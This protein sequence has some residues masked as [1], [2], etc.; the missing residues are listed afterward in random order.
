MLW[1]SV[2]LGLLM[3][4][5]F[6]CT[7]SGLLVGSV[8]DNKHKGE[9][10]TKVPELT[11][12]DELKVTFY[13]DSTINAIYDTI[14]V[15]KLMDYENRYEEFVT[16]FAATIKYPSLLSQYFLED[17]LYTFYGF[18]YKSILFKDDE[19]NVLQ[20]SLTERRNDGRITQLKKRESWKDFFE[21]LEI[22]GVPS[23]QTLFIIADN[24]RIPIDTGRILYVRTKNTNSVLVMGGL[25]LATD[26]ILLYQLSKPISQGGLGLNIF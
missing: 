22:Y 9:L 17:K 25:G 14:L 23:Y 24:V 3:T 26:L 19:K 18:D 11:R 15:M 6:G 16:T 5:L 20:I 10:V 2:V 8:M 21:V 4:I 12:G 13:N 1:N 7:A